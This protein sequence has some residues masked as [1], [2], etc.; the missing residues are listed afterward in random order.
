MR[1]SRQPWA[2]LTLSLAVI[3]SGCTGGQTGQPNG[4]CTVDGRETVTFA[5]AAERGFDIEALLPAI[6]IGQEWVEHEVVLVT[7][8]DLWTKRGRT[9]PSDLAV[10][11]KLRLRLTGEAEVVSLNESTRDCHTPVLLWVEAELEI[12]ELHEVLA[13]RPAR[14]PT[15]WFFTEGEP[16]VFND[17]ELELSELG[18]CFWTEEAKALSCVTPTYARAECVDDG[19][20]RSAPRLSIAAR[21]ATEVLAHALEAL[22]AQ[23]DCHGAPPMSF[24]IGVQPIEPFCTPAVWDPAGDPMPVIGT[25]SS[26][27]FESPAPRL[28]FLAVNPGVRCFPPGLAPCADQLGLCSEGEESEE[29]CD[30]VSVT[31]GGLGNA[32]G[33]HVTV[34][35][36]A[37]EMVTV[38]A[39]VTSGSNVSC[40]AVIRTQL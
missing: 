38:T 39:N 23:L 3:A 31:V 30:R 11:A 19:T 20:W 24:E 27:R 14:G 36:D 12:P 35:V 5:E 4:I 8:P 26:D 37:T 16:Q 32:H 2:W 17:A 29:M 33:Y 13:G 10:H 21:S 6:S 15:I 28:G 40:D 34:D 18:Q 9:P 22:P 1:G 25:L 7:Q